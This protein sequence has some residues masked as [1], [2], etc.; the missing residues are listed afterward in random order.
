MASLVPLPTPVAI[1]DQWEYAALPD[2]AAATV[3]AL[4]A[5]AFDH[6]PVDDYSATP[7]GLT[8]AVLIVHDGKIVAERYGPDIDAE[9]TLIS[10][11]M[12]KSITQA[13]LGRLALQGIIDPDAPL[14]IPEWAADRRRWIRMSDLLSMRSGLRWSEDYVDADGSDCLQML[15][16]SGG[17]DMAAYAA[18][19]P[20]IHAPDEV[21]NYSS[22]TTNIISRIC[23]N[24]LLKAG[25]DPAESLSELFELL[26]MSSATAT[27]DPAGTFVGSSYVYATA[28]DFAR[29]GQWYLN[30]GVWNGSQ[31]LPD[32]W[33]DRARSIRSVD[34]ENGHGYGE[35]W[36]AEPNDS[37]GWFWAN[38]YEGQSTN[39]IPASR[40][41]MVRLGKS[42]VE[43]SE[44]LTRWRRALVHAFD[45]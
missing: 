35:Q 2:H 31:Q 44:A 37:S 23:S 11:S 6:Q 26:G 10:W 8:L 15:F 33:V 24:A 25:I 34:P 18:S 3:E 12:A 21:F 38:G 7:L 28:R 27:F 39:V 29:L 4:L 16:G 13:W 20:A 45:E 9:T 36:W 5:E 17:Q 1:G 19:L 22:G 32:G 30:G 14:E 43:H 41:V 40:T 42:P